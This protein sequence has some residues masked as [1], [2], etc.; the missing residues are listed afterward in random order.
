MMDSASEIARQSGGII[1][2]AAVQQLLDFAPR[3]D[4]GPE[5]SEW[6]GYDQY[7][8]H[9]YE[10]PRGSARP[11]TR[12]GRAFLKR[13]F[14]FV[15]DYCA[16]EVRWRHSL[17]GYSKAPGGQKLVTDQEKF[18]A[19]NNCGK[20]GLMTA[21]SVYPDL[22]FDDVREVLKSRTVEYAP[23]DDYYVDPNAKSRKPYEFEVD[24]KKREL[25]QRFKG[26]IVAY[27]QGGDDHRTAVNKVAS[28]HN[29]TFA[30]KA[31]LMIE[32]AKVI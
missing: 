30:K 20:L 3:F 7:R 29:L 12:P 15:A 32:A 6:D 14:R 24:R 1:D 10:A 21:R 31:I 22:N 17:E 26:E 18:E 9:R 16:D 11:S 27:M 13:W 23:L 19:L 5:P 28:T 4:A 2:D 8:D 25:W